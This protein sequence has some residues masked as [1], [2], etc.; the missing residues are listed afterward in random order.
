[1]KA[2]WICTEGESILGCTNPCPRDYDAMGHLWSCVWI[3]LN[4]TNET[5]QRV[6]ELIHFILAA[7]WCGAISASDAMLVTDESRTTHAANAVIISI[8]MGSI[9][10]PILP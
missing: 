2:V 6:P 9:F 10:W 8:F 3:F 1:M 4:K 7:L 5:M